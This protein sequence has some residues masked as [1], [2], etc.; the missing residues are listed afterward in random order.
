MGIKEIEPAGY[1]IKN[2]E[3]FYTTEQ[4][5]NRVSQ[6]E[7]QLNRIRAFSTPPFVNPLNALVAVKELVD[8][9]L[10]EQK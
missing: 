10:E 7:G 6:L 3:P 8:E 4:Y 5:I 9:V 2:G 1:S